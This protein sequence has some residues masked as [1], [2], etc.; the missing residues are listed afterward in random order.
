MQI[1]IIKLEGAARARGSF[2]RTRESASNQAI[3]SRDSARRDAESGRRV[4]RHKISSS[5]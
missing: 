2:V 4:S 1:R 3:S 5:Q